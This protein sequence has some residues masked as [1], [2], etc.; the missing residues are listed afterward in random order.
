M[1]WNTFPVEVVF[2]RRETPSIVHLGFRRVDGEPFQYAAGQFINLHFER[3]GQPA[4]R[5]YSVANPPGAS[6]VFE[7][8]MSPVEGGLAT[9]ALGAAQPG[10][11]LTASGPYGRFVL[12]DDPP[13]RLVLV[14]TGTGITPYR[15]MLPELAQRVAHDGFRAHV[16]LGV[17]RREEALFGDDF[18]GARDR[19]GIAFTAC[20][21]RDYPEEPRPWEHAGYVQT[22]FGQLDL[23]PESDIVYLCGNPGMVDEAAAWLKEREFG[24]RQIRREKYVSARN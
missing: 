12:K 11:R 9:R 7:I 16:L 21:S 1:K 17:W 22:L 8:A 15:S 10:D 23:H 19:S 18:L 6:D 3:D 13:C 14:G 24:A 20:Y 5:S 4:H 2:T